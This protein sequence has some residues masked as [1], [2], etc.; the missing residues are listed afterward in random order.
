M[1]I[2]TLLWTIALVVGS[3]SASA[4]AVSCGSEPTDSR[5]LAVCGLAP[6]SW[7][8]DGTWRPEGSGVF[9]RWTDT[10]NNERVGIITVQHF[11]DGAAPTTDACDSQTDSWYAYFQACATP[12]GSC[13]CYPLCIGENEYMIRV[14]VECFRR[15]TEPFR[16][17]SDGVVIGDI[18]PD[19]L[20]LLDHIEP[21]E[22]ESPQNLSMCTGDLI[23]VA[24]WGRTRSVE[25]GESISSEYE[26]RS[27]HVGV[28]SLAGIGCTKDGRKGGIQ[29]AQGGYHPE[30]G[31]QPYA[32]AECHDSGGGVFVEASGGSLRLVGV[33]VTSTSAFMAVSHQAISAPND[34]TYLCRPC[35]PEACGDI[36]GDELHLQNCDDAD[37]LEDAGELAVTPWCLGDMDGD[38]IAGT[39]LDINLIKCGFIST[40]DRNQWC[41]GDANLDGY[42]LIDDLEIIQSIRATGTAPNYSVNCPS[43]GACGAPYEWCQGDINFDGVIDAT[44]ESEVQSLLS[45]STNQAGYRCYQGAEGC[46]APVDCEWPSP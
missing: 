43:C 14:R 28:T 25:C 26:A 21:I 39:K 36:N 40:C 27:L 15:A 35:R 10:Q 17:G 29:M 16:A 5:F 31:C 41:Y 32:R 7:A 18:E 3:G 46:P 11:L 2:E 23:Y 20:C 8:A 24:G 9:V 13:P 22:I 33:I 34:T 30:N 45:S 12:C 1:K 38:G 37:C 44:D 4:L 42:L 19:D 6:R